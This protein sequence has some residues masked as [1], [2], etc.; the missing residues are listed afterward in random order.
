VTVASLV[1]TWREE[2]RR[3]I[4]LDELQGV[5]DRTVVSSPGGETGES[6]DVEGMGAP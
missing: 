1:S 5:I 4:P 3:V 6:R 2:P